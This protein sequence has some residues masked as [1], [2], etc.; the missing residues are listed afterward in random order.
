M[1]SEESDLRPLW[2][3]A[4]RFGPEVPFPPYRFAG[5]GRP[6]PVRNP[7]GHSYRVVDPGWS[8]PAR[9]TRGVDLFHAGYLWEAHEAWE[10]LWKA[11]PAGPAKAFYQGLIL[12]SA[13]LLKAQLGNRRGAKRL[14]RLAGGRLGEAGGPRHGIDPVAVVLALEHCLGPPLDLDRAPRLVARGWQGRRPS[15]GI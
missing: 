7:A 10:P 11:A 6:H 5:R 3:D 8:A 2:P 14:A 4:P 1:L 9:F 13:A 15:E 12:V